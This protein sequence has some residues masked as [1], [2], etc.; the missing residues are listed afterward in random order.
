MFLWILNQVLYNWY[1]ALFFFIK[2][3]YVG[4]IG[5]S[6]NIYN[7]KKDELPQEVLISLTWNQTSGQTTQEN[8]RNPDQVSKKFEI[9]KLF[10]LLRN[11][12][13]NNKVQFEI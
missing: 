1:I 13:E 9:N 2:V 3:C 5:N 12:K 7:N 11:W 10:K 4:Y 6:L 8:K